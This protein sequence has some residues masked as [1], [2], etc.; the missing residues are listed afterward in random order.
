MPKQKTPPETE[1]EPLPE[2]SENILENVK[3]IKKLKLQRSV[4]NKLVASELNQSAGDEGADPVKT[5][6]TNITKKRQ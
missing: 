3:Y 4:L 5:V 1:N 6:N 2:N